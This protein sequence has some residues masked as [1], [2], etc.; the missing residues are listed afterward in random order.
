M[1]SVTDGDVVAGGIVDDDGKNFLL[2][3]LTQKVYTMYKQRR[4]CD[5]DSTQSMGQQPR[6]P[7][8][9]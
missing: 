9:P 6:T 2:T 1:K 7:F 5:A 8:L 3:V 4:F